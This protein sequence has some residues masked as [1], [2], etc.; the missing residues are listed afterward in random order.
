MGNFDEDGLEALVNAL[1]PSF[2]SRFG[3]VCWAQ[4][5]TYCRLVNYRDRDTVGYFWNIEITHS[6]DSNS[7]FSTGAGFGWWV[8]ILGS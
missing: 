7:F 8:S 6:S 5:G 2:T 4:G 3:E 1:A